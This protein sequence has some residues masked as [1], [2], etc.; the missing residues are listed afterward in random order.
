MK[1]FIFDFDGVIVDS[2]RHWIT[3]G[4]DVFF[5]SIVPGWTRAD[6]ARMMGLGVESSHEFLTREYG[7]RMPFSEFSR[8]LEECVDVVYG[9]RAKPLPGLDVLLAYLAR[10]NIPIGIA[11][12]S[13]RRWIEKALERLGLR[14]HFRTIRSGDDV[15]DRTKPHPDVYLLA[16]GDLGAEPATCVVIEDSTNGV[17]AAKAAGMTCI[18]L[19]TDV[20][21]EQ[22]LSQADTLV[23]QLDAVP[24]ILTRFAPRS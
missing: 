20:N 1:A 15:G 5:P 11:S 12:S 8:R 7:L 24:D 3:L 4:D 23:T 14:H 13:K 16:A 18:A 9:E 2:E 6:G 21:G 19:R 17:A 10:N 22:D